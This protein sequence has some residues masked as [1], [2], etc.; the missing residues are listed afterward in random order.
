M[1]ACFQ[2]CPCTHTIFNTRC[3]QTTHKVEQKWKISRDQT[4]KQQE[5][6][7]SAGRVKHILIKL[8]GVK[9][10]DLAHVAVCRSALVSMNCLLAVLDCTSVSAARLCPWLG[11][12]PAFPLHLRRATL[13]AA[14]SDTAIS[15]FII[16]CKE[17]AQG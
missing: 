4:R 7:M 17:K 8:L 3:Y 16:V 6:T 9:K 14:P 11:Y 5:Q 12:S 2:S 13:R 15:F 1:I 10:A